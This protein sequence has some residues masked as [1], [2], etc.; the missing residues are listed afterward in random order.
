MLAS[1]QIETICNL[2]AANKNTT[3]I[4]LCGSYIYGKP[5]DESDLDIRV[6]TND[7]SG[8][9]GRGLR[10]FDTDIELLVN[11][12]ERIR[13]YFQECIETGIP[14]A[15]HFWAHG[16]IVLDRTGV[17]AELQREAQELWRRGPNTGTWQHKKTRASGLAPY[18]HKT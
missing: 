13:R 18:T 3:G 6:V 8:F 12:P 17:L 2:F 7:G 11:P 16:K 15:V 9:D 10:M 4:L 14:F 5:T 1:E